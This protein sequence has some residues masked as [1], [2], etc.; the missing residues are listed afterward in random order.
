MRND[1][2]I[3]II[4]VKYIWLGMIA[5]IK[6]ERYY[7][8]EKSSHGLAKQKVFYIKIMQR[9]RTIKLSNIVTIKDLFKLSKFKQFA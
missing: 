9:Q 4:L 7:M 8:I 2:N 1:R 6:E 3:V 5:K